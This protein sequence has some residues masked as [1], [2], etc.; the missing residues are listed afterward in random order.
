MFQ[1]VL[2]LEQTSPLVL[3]AIVH[4]IG[5]VPDLNCFPFLNLRQSF[6]IQGLPE[7]ALSPLHSKA[8]LVSCLLK[9]QQEL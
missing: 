1:L 8:K 6:R 5:K 9:A 2:A 7:L 3:K 4:N